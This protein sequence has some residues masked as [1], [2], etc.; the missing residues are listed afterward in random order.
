MKNLYTALRNENHLKNDGRYQLAIFLKNI[1]LSTDDALE[2]WR[3]EF[4]KKMNADDFETEY[5]YRLRHAFGEEGSRKEY[6]GWT[7]R[8]IIKKK[9]PGKGEYHGCPFKYFSNS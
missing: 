1:G 3:R 6:N 9:L 7:C 8:T 5:G 4:T 2:F